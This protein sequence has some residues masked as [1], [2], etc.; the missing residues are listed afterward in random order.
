MECISAKCVPGRLEP[1]S[2]LSGHGAH[3]K[4]RAL[5]FDPKS[6]CVLPLAVHFGTPASDT[7]RFPI[8][9]SA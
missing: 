8:C 5:W 1:V 3:N 9:P 4:N 7:S 6:C 2:T